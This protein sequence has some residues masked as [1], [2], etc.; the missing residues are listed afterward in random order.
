MEV[1]III[2]VLDALASHIEDLCNGSTPDSD[3]VCGGSNPSSS[4]NKKAPF[5]YRTKG[6]F[7]SDAFLRNEMHTSCVMQASPVMHACG[8]W[9]ERIASPIT[10]QLHHLSVIFTV[11]WS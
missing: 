9:V 6:A 7:L 11:I 4:A 5:V 3:S 8:A 2:T 1:R 10:A